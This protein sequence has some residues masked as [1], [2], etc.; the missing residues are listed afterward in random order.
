MKRLSELVRLLGYEKSCEVLS[1]HISRSSISIMTIVCN[2]GIHPIP[3]EFVKGEVYIASSGSLD[4]SSSES[5][6]VQYEAILSRLSKKLKEKKLEQNLHF[7]IWARNFINANKA[8][9]VSHYQNRGD[10]NTL[11]W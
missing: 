7:T 11:S 5:V 6:A 9:S 8:T 3:I 10:R 1:S 2:E 4:F